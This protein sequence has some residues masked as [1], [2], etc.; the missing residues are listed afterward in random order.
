MRYEQL[1]TEQ[2]VV[3][4]EDACHNLRL[5]GTTQQAYLSRD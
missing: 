2:L 1:K 5:L 4:S 3:M